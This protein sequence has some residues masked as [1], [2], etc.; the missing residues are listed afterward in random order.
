[1]KKKTLNY[2]DEKIF[3]LSLHCIVIKLIM[4]KGFRFL[5][6]ELNLIIIS[7]TRTPL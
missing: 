5:V 3:T 2:K 1:M 6:H 4:L 7:V